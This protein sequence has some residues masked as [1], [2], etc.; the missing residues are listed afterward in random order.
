L[1]LIKRQEKS[2]CILLLLVFICHW[3]GRSVVSTFHKRSQPT[4]L[5]S[6][7]Q[8][9]IG[10]TM[11]FQSRPPPEM[12]IVLFFALRLKEKQKVRR[13]HFTVVYRY[14]VSG[15]YCRPSIG[16]MRWLKWTATFPS[17]KQ[18]AHHHSCG[19][20]RASC[21]GQRVVALVAAVAI[22]KRYVNR[23]SF[24][25]VVKSAYLICSRVVAFLA[26]SETQPCPKIR[27]A[28]LCFLVFLCALPL[29]LV[30]YSLQSRHPAPGLS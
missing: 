27:Y 11:V 6:A 29:P 10:T 12:N 16:S 2:Y 28:K 26:A 18:I 4:E 8:S 14:G 23:Q 3:V 19:A 9:A 1:S 17:N 22:Y 21:A 13:S 30:P 20:G 15:T 25:I 24:P 7:L 5:Q